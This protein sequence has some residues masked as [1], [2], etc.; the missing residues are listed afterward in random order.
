M[1]GGDGPA[2]LFYLLLCSGTNW[3]GMFRMEK[4][5]GKRRKRKE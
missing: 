1:I 4:L 2:S 5:G 3:R